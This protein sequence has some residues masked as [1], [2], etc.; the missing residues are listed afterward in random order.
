MVKCFL[1][2]FLL[3][4]SVVYGQR[5]ITPT[6]TLRIEG[7]VKHPKMFVIADFDSFPEQSF[8]TI[9]ITNQTGEAKKT[10]NNPKGIPLKK[11]L[12]TIELQVEKPKFLNE[13]Y[14][15]FVASDGYKAVFSWNEIFNTDIGTNTFILT[16]YNG[17]KGKDIAQRIVLIAS[18]DFI[19]GR[20]YIKGLQKI[21]VERVK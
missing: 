3:L 8:A 12:E 17:I 13:Y 10:I 1:S 21:I 2:I 4:S 14:F 18:K 6:D 7:M 20:R 11:I 5:N 16:E 19:S 15:I 9:E